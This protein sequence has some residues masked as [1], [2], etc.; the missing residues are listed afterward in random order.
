[1][2]SSDFCPARQSI[3]ILLLLLR[4][5]QNLLEGTLKKVPKREESGEG[6]QIILG[7]I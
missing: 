5:Q 3:F 1:M 7:I 6:I 4:G 2:F